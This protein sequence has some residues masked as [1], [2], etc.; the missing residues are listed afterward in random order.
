MPECMKRVKA[1]REYRLAST[2]S[3]T[4]KLAD[5]PTRF[6]VENMPDG[7]YI[8]VP[9][10]SSEKRDYVPMGF[11][12]QNDLSSNLVLIIPSA[13]LFHFGILE[14]SVH[15]AW[16]RAVCGRLKSGY[17]YSKDIVYNNFP[18]PV[19]TPAYSSPAHDSSPKS[20]PR[21]PPLRWPRTMATPRAV[22]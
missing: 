17:R 8:V 2:R 20:P 14:S 22:P 4:L 13:T 6:Q 19:C 3:S 21:T 10:V 9:S 12:S 1:V 15:M 11:L 5:K 16:M 18:W 7:D